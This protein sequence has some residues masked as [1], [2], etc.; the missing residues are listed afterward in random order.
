MP[1]PD[2]LLAATRTA[3]HVT[4]MLASTLVA[5]APAD[6]LQP[7]RGFAI[8]RTEVSIAQFARYV[9]ATGTVTAAEKAGGGSTYEGGW[10]QRPGWT[11]RTLSRWPAPA[12][13]SHCS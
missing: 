10:V 6:D 5:A 11:W 2:T 9:Q 8:D 3:L 1:R 12:A 4:A 13:R 7:I